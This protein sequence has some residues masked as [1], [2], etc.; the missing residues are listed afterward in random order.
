MRRA[1]V[2]LTALVP[3]AL[4]LAAC[5]GE[6]G[7]RSEAPAGSEPQPVPAPAPG[8]PPVAT[9]PAAYVGDWAT[10][11]ALCAE[12]RF[13]ITETSLA[14]AGEVSCQWSPGDVR[15]TPEGW[16]IAARC[17]AEGPEQPATLAVTGGGDSLL[18]RGAPFEPLP[19]GRCETPA[20]PQG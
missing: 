3:A 11:P 15:K 5:G 9:A 6:A 14:T 2:L 19:L 8:E 16:T 18:V 10:S 12:G 17:R 1:A 7:G 20:P 4:L 13:R